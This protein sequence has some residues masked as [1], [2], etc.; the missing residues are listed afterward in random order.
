MIAAADGNSYGLTAVVIYLLVYSFMNLG[1]FSVIVLMRRKDLLGDEIDDL[2]GLMSR[3]PGMALLMLIFLL[4]LAG[5]PPTAGFI[6]KYYIFLSLIQTGHYY[7]A[8]LGV[9][10]AVV[11]LYY[12]FRIVVAMFMKKALET[13]PLAIGPGLSVALGVTLGFTLII[14]IYPEPFIQLAQDAI[15]PFFS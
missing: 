15:R 3:A 7:L 14:G 6:G 2:S 8:I 10:Y 12:Y 11:A 13:G 1:A 5:I 4:S 9:G